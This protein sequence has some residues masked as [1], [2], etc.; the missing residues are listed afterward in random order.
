MRAPTRSWPG[1]WKRSR[2]IC[3]SCR[4]PAQLTAFCPLEG[5]AA[6]RV[7]DEVLADI[8]ALKLNVG[9]YENSLSSAGGKN[10]FVSQIR[11][12]PNS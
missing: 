12:P 9:L 7:A 3:R 5:P 10:H 6:K 11:A 4:T 2:N 1:Q 8:P